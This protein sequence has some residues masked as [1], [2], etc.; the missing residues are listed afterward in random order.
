MYVRIFIFLSLIYQ[1][2][3]P[4]HSLIDPASDTFHS[5]VSLF[6]LTKGLRYLRISPHLCSPF[7]H[8]LKKSVIGSLSLFHFPI[9]SLKPCPSRLRFRFDEDNYHP[10]PYFSCRQPVDV[11]MVVDGRSAWSFCR[12]D[13][14]VTMAFDAAHDSRSHIRPVHAIVI[15]F[16]G[17]PANE[18]SAIKHFAHPSNA[19]NPM[20]M[21]L[22]MPR[23]LKDSDPQ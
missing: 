10:T 21:I 2:I 5:S 8:P 15:L 13:M 22:R 20:K 3:F 23:A 12:Q 7:I 17:D 11:M 14:G 16:C 4:S 19:R 1:S 6:F 18:H 9:L